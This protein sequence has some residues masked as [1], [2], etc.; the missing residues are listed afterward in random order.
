[1]ATLEGLDIS[2]W[3]QGLQ[4]AKTGKAFAIMKATDGT[5]YVDPTCNGFVSQAKKAGML[6]GVYHFW[7]GSG[8]AEADWFCKNVAGYVGDGVLVLDFEGAHA[9]SATEAKKFLDRVYDK[10]G[11]RPL[12][13]MS[14]SVTNQFNWSSVAKDYGLWVARYGSSSYGS[15]GA[16]GAPAMWQYT[17]TGRV[18][19]Y[20]GD[21][22]LDTFYGDRNAWLAYATGGSHTDNDITGGDWF[23]MATEQDLINAIS[24]WAKSTD[25]RKE[26][27]NAVWNTDGVIEAPDGEG[28]KDN[29]YWS[30][31]GWLGS[32][33]TQA[34]TKD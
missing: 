13:Y 34:M 24:K 27:A 30:G 17:S 11:I 14:Q 23:E 32:I 21:V 28:K 20:S 4:L 12:I 18:T 5:G 19:G 3:Q 2:H 26:I 10:T 6:F 31:R 8:V 7:Q 33:R 9:T 16:W 15:T 29:P 22:D 25:G 1:M